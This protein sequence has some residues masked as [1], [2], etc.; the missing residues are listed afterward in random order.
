MRCDLSQPKNKHSSGSWVAPQL[1]L[2]EVWCLGSARWASAKMLPEEAVCWNLFLCA[3]SARQLFATEKQQHLES[4]QQIFQGFPVP[5]VHRA[6]GLLAASTAAAL[7]DC[8]QST[9]LF[10]P[11]L[12][13]NAAF[14][15]LNFMALIF[16]RFGSNE[17]LPN[18]CSSV[19][20]ADHQTGH[21]RALSNPCRTQHLCQ[22]SFFPE[23]YF[24]K[25]TKPAESVC[26]YYFYIYFL[27]ELDWFGLL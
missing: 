19:L 3:D 20:S 2:C 24:A 22:P 12:L 13:S 16:D 21:L 10:S 1:L 4:K 6:S 8:C 15:S 25:Q 9:G 11:F 17:M 23:C 14:M 7:Q 18:S 5:T 27:I 26:L